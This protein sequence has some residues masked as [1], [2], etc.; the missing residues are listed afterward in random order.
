[1]SGRLAENHNKALYELIY[2]ATYCLR[3]PT[4]MTIKNKRCSNASVQIACRFLGKRIVQAAIYRPTRSDP[5]KNW[6]GGRPS[7]LAVSK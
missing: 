3:L 4:S 2:F 7:L 1:M 6:V 5:T